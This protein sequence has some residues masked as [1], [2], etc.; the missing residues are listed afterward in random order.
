MHWSFPDHGCPVRRA[1]GA[2]SLVEVVVACFL[3]SLIALSV[4][5]GLQYASTMARL[6]TNALVAK[7]IAQGYLEQMMIDDFDHVD[8]DHY[9]NITVDTVP[10]VYIDQTL[11][12]RCAVTFTFKGFGTLVDSSVNTLVE[13]EAKTRWVKDEWAGDTVFLVS[14][15]GAG[16]SALIAGNNIK[17]LDLAAP[18]A[19]KPSK[20]TGYLIN[21]GKT[22]EIATTWTYR[23]REYHQ[24]IESLI[25][26]TRSRKGLGF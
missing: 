2:F 20:G 24:T 5:G 22:V 3:L 16:Q 9:P 7:N 15:D 23:G 14:G 25:V 10:P 8:A 17:Q 19:Y 4:V 1:R 21:N 11:D 18:L 13:D 12:I 6:N 26:N